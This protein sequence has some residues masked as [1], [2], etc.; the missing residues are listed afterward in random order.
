MPVITWAAPLRSGFA[1]PHD[2]LH[3]RGPAEHHSSEVLNKAAL[4]SALNAYG[5]RIQAF[6]GGA[7]PKSASIRGRKSPLAAVMQNADQK[8]EAVQT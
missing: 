8:V 6:A 1:R 3:E 5:A 7:P 4:L 2:G